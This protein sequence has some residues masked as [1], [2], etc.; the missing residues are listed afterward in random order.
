MVPSPHTESTS[1]GVKSF[2]HQKCFCKTLRKSRHVSA[3]VLPQSFLMCLQCG[4]TS[5]PLGVSVDFSATSKEGKVHSTLP[6]SPP[7]KDMMARCRAFVRDSGSD[8]ICIQPSRSTSPWWNH[9]SM[10]SNL[11]HLRTRVRASQSFAQFWKKHSFSCGARSMLIYFVPQ[12]RQSERGERNVEGAKASRR[13]DH[14]SFPADPA[15]ISLN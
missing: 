11:M 10:A 3:G 4:L 2:I 14:C 1:P 7:C 13:L 9:K 8:E 6:L 15:W 5:H 12:E